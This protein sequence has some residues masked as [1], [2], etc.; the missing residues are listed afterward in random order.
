MRKPQA[1]SQ[2]SAA[3]LEWLEQRRLDLI[4]AYRATLEADGEP[5]TV[6]QLN[7]AVERWTDFALGRTRVA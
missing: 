1:S 3:M 7:A 4:A 5:M 2:N 6:E